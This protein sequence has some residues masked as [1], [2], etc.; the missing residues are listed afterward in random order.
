MNDCILLFPPLV[1]TVTNCFANYVKILLSAYSNIIIACVTFHVNKLPK[2][3]S[4][5]FCFLQ[6]S[7]FLNQSDFD[8]LAHKYNV[9]PFL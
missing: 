7:R 9:Y 6:T 2:K 1:K 8:T 5:T 4:N 3:M